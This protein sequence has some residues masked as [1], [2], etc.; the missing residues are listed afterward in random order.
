MQSKTSFFNATLFKKNLSRIW[1]LG[2][3]YFMLLLLAMPVSYGL[4]YANYLKFNGTDTLHMGD[5][6]FLDSVT[7][8]LDGLLPCITAIIT[9]VLVF[10]YLYNQ[11]AS[12]TIH[13]LPISRG[14][15]YFTGML[16][17]FVILIVPHILVT[18]IMLIQGAVY[19]VSGDVLVTVLFW[20][21]C[22]LSY[23]VL[24]LGLASFAAM[25]SGQTAAVVIF[26]FIFNFLYSGIQYVIGL[27]ME[28][29]GFGLYDVTR[30]IAISPW[31]PIFYTA[32]YDYMGI[33]Y[34]R[35][36][37]ST[38]EGATVA[39]LTFKY[40]GTGYVPVY[41]VA[42]LILAV[43]GC[44][45]YLKKQN[46]TVSDFISVPVV[47]PIYKFGMSFFIG[48]F[49]ATVCGEAIATSLCFS[50]GIKVALILVFLVIAECI[51]YYLM[52]MLIEKD[53]RV[54]NMKRFRQYACFAAVSLVIVTAIKFDALGFE[55][56]VPAVDDVKW[57]VIE[58]N[59]QLLFEEPSEI[60]KVIEAHEM[61]LANKKEIQ[62]M[63]YD[64]SNTHMNAVTFKYRLNN[65]KTINRRY[66]MQDERDEKNSADYRNCTN[67]LL[68]VVN[69]P[70]TI[71]RSII[72]TAYDTAKV[73]NF[74][75][76][77][78]KMKEDGSGGYDY[79]TPVP[80]SDKL[81]LEVYGEKFYKALL[82]DIDENGWGQQHLYIKQDD[83]RIANPSYLNLYSAECSR[84]GNGAFYG[85]YPATNNYMETFGLELNFDCRNAIEALIEMGF[86]ESEDDLITYAEMY[87][88]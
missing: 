65:G 68:S 16:S 22:K 55:D 83:E 14:A 86:I 76:E 1:L 43:L 64:R 46:E 59:N 58:V 20:F 37:A 27:F 35:Y 84:T 79:V 18:I 72:G 15:L 28:T 25:L 11:R 10:G 26:Y 9:I 63:E 41:L 88:Q 85:Y 62:P 49:V 77:L 69:N 34:T 33:S 61:I 80:I 30:D 21:W 87:K 5:Q 67:Y 71:K 17:A 3:A 78:I 32:S 73:I 66:V 54:F 38:V 50:Y 36:T 56:K 44:F 57:A 31:C 4:N 52:E 53:F 82:K 39:P 42:G 29:V 75:F 23:T 81:S 2:L 6:Y 40:C 45:I 60:E 70:E 51:V 48:L 74:N 12:Y 13:A 7:M 19:K 24:F 8:L 47:K